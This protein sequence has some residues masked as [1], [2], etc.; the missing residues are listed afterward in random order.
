MIEIHAVTLAALLMLSVPGLIVAA[1]LSFPWA[2]WLYLS[3]RLCLLWCAEK[4]RS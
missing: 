2:V 4:I 1:L 3:I